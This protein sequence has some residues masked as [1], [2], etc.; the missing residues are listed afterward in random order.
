MSVNLRLAGY[1]KLIDQMDSEP[2]CV[3]DYDGTDAN[4]KEYIDN[5]ML[6]NLANEDISLIP[7]CECGELKG[8]QYLGRTCANVGCNTIVKSILDEEVDFRVW[9]RQPK[10]VSKLIQPW[11]LYIIL[12]RYKITKPS[13]QLVEYIIQTN[14]RIT[15]NKLS[16]IHQLEKLDFILEQRGIKRG[17]NSFVD[18]FDEIIEILEMNFCRTGRIADKEKFVQWA[19]S[20]KDDVILNSYLP[21]LNRSLFILDNSDGIRY[22]NRDMTVIVNAVRRMTGVDIRDL[23]EANLQN[24]T[25][26]TLCD[27]ANFYGGYFANKIFTKH[28][29]YRQNITRARSHFTLRAVVSSRSDKHRPNE[30]LFPWSGATSVFSL[31]IISGL[32]ERGFTFKDALDHLNEHVNMYSPIIREIFDEIIAG[33]K[34]G[35][36]ELANILTE[37]GEPVELYGHPTASNRNPSLGRGSYLSQ[38]IWG[39]KDD[40]SDNTVDISPQ[41]SPTTNMDYDGDMLMFTLM[42]TDKARK[43]IKPFEYHNNILGMRKP[44]EFTNALSIPKSDIGTVANWLYNEDLS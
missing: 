35:R 33:T 34:Y 3:N 10:Y 20:I 23:G 29:L 2:F 11:F 40:P 30:I 17:Y 38:Y 16:N 42:M 26:K 9:I 8:Y 22:M 36:Y 31:H 37:L 6:T 4:V 28:A 24:R 5:K 7:S 44:N 21:V 14:Y 43:A 19:R 25:A 27:F 13:I 1:D 12:N 41:N 39:I 18:N 15:G 32:M